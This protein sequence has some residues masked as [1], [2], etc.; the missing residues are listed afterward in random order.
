MAEGI[1]TLPGIMKLRD[2]ASTV[3]SQLAHWTVIE[4]KKT[5]WLDV[6]SVSRSFP[7]FIQRKVPSATIS[8]HPLLIAAR[9]CSKSRNPG[10]FLEPFRD[11]RVSMTFQSNNA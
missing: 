8:L 9:L 7:S 3:A 2:T 1:L 4:T 5:Q 6:Q 11:D 10:G